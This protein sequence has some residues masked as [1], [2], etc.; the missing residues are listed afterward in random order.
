MRRTGP[1]RRCA[2]SN[3]YQRSAGAPTATRS[4]A[5]SPALGGEAGDEAVR[6]RRRGGRTRRRRRPRRARPR[7]AAP[8]GSPRSQVLGPDPGIDRSPA[9]AP[10]R[11]GSANGP[12]RV[13]SPV[14]VA[15][16]HVHPRRARRT[17]RRSG[18]PAAGRRRRATRS[19]RGVPSRTTAT[20]SPIVSASS[21]S[22]VTWTIVV[23]TVSCRRRSSTRMSARSGGSRFDSGSS[24]SR[25]AGSADQRPGEGDPLALAARQL[26]RAAGASRS[27]QPTSSAIAA[28]PPADLALAAPCARPGRTRCSRR[29]RGGGTG[30]SSGT[31]S[32]RRAGLPA[33]R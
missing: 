24:S 5:R 29:R 7:R 15:A 10:S 13:A 17:W 21:W 4:P 25:I 20:R 6:R 12:A 19:V 16:E 18:S 14:G 26:C 2:R 28:D 27:A 30:R 9:T 23:P 1:S 33:G 31:P 3:R 8:S 32:R 11:A 22:W